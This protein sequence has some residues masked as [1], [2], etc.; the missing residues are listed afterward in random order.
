MVKYDKR[1]LKN[2]LIAYDLILLA[3]IL[4][5]LYRRNIISFSSLNSMLLVFILIIVCVVVYI[6]SRI[7]HYQLEH[8]EIKEAVKIASTHNKKGS[9]TLKSAKSKINIDYV[10]RERLIRMDS[11][12]LTGFLFGLGFFT[13]LIVVYFVLTILSLV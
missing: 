2:L 7:H 3:G 6:F 5:I 10:N 8:T 1:L 11:P 13:A 9:K 4:F 12:F